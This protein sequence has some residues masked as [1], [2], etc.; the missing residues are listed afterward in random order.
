MDATQI[1]IDSGT[2]FD[3]CPGGIGLQTERP[4]KPG[5][6]LALIIECPDSDEEICIPEARVE[7]MKNDRFGLSIRTMKAEDRD[8]LH[9]AFSSTRRLAQNMLP[10]TAR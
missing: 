1:V 4:L 8:R 7:W 9:R 2:I 3:L 6:E 10:S 5:M